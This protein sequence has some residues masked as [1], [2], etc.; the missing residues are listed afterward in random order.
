SV[1]NPAVA[2]IVAELIEQLPRGAQV[3]MGSRGVPELG[4]GRL[5]AR[6]R[7]L[8]ID[9]SHLRFSE[10]EADGFLRRQ[11][12]LELAPEDV[13]RL[14]RSTE[15]WAAALWLASVSLENRAEPGS[16]IASFSGSNAAVV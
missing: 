3:I 5:R 1:Q 14:H 7:L 4:L 12:R 8:E 11:R 2:A 6:G 10:S 16:F 15:G 13:R 9:P